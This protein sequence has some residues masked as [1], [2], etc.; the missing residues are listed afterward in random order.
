MKL[1]VSPPWRPR[2]C[3]ASTGQPMCQTLANEAAA[4]GACSRRDMLYVDSQIRMRAILWFGIVLLPASVLT[5]G[6]NKPETFA[7][8]RDHFKYGSIGA[9]SRAGVPYWI[10]TVLPRMFPDHLPNRPGNGYA[11][12]GLI[13]K[14]D[15]ASRPIGTSYRETQTGLVGLNC[16]VCHTGTIRESPT[17]PRQIVLG[18]PA[19]QFDLQSYERFFFACAKDRRFTADNLLQA[20]RQVNPRFG[21]F[22][23]LLYRWFVIPR[24]RDG[25]LEQSRNFAW[26][27]TRPPQGPGR[28]DTFNPYKVFFGFQMSAEHGVGT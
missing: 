13:F 8:I 9:E 5:L 19:H 15:K 22:D 6:R 20:I 11:R 17:A 27:D 25:I 24:T 26:F 7:D 12:F 1:L 16:G 14:S 3:R 23:G 28:V 21:W 18:M 4:S 2:A 10:W